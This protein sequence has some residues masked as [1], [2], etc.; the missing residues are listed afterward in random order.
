MKTGID[1]AR[2]AAVVLNMA[3]VARRILIASSGE[4][5]ATS[6]EGQAIEDTAANL[7]YN[8]MNKRLIVGSV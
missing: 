7:V 8:D 1:H 5:T 3:E 2:E 4:E 6:L